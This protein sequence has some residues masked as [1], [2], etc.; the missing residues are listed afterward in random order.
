MRY[1]WSHG[2]GHTYCRDS[3]ITAHDFLNQIE[4]PE[5]DGTDGLEPEG[6]G[7][8]PN[9]EVQVGRE[10]GMEMLEYGMDERENEYLGGSDTELE[11]WNMEQE[12][13]DDDDSDEMLLHM[14]DMYYS[15]VL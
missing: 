4:H 6:Y 3:N 7:E 11:P 1:H 9:D 14:D 8:H 2:I 10:S 13:L 12:D 15:Q 5:D